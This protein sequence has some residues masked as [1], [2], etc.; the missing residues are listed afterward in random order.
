MGA[1]LLAWVLHHREPTKDEVIAAQASIE[2]LREPERR[3]SFVKIRAEDDLVFLQDEMYALLEK[4]HFDPSAIHQKKKIYSAQL[5]IYYMIFSIVIIMRIKPSNYRK[6][7]L[8]L[9]RAMFGQELHRH[10]V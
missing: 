8:T 7:P 3:L 6:K 4:I 5:R 1:E 2:A 10:E 9:N